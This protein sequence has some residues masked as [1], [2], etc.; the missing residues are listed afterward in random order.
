[1]IATWRAATPV[2]SGVPEA[3]GEPAR[4]VGRAAK[5]AALATTAAPGRTVAQ[6]TI[7]AKTTRSNQ[8]VQGSLL[9]S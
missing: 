5:A 3:I 8:R 9:L 6:A 2:P 7:V 1:M 4:I